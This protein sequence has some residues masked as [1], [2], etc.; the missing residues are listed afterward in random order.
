MRIIIT[1]L[2]LLQIHVGSGQ[3]VKL[4]IP[5][6]IPSLILSLQYSNDGNYIATGHEDN[7]LR[8]WDVRSGKLMHQLPGHQSGIFDIQFSDDDQYL[9]TNSY[10]Q[11]AIL[12]DFNTLTPIQKFSGGIQYEPTATLSHSGKFVIYYKPQ[13]YMVRYSIATNETEATFHGAQNQ[14]SEF[15]LSPDDKY[16]AI[17]AKDGS[18]YVHDAVTG[19]IIDQYRSHNR[20]I[21]A[22]AFHPLK[23]LLASGS[24]EK[25]II[26]NN[27][28]AK[29]ILY[30]FKKLKGSTYD[31]AFSPDGKCLFA[32]G[33]S[34]KHFLINTE[35]GKI[36]KKLTGQSV[37]SMGST[38]FSDNGQYLFVSGYGKNA[39]GIYEIETGK[40]TVFQ[41]RS[42]FPN[43]AD[44]NE[45]ENEIA[46]G[47]YGENEITRYK[48]TSGEI[49]HPIAGKLSAIFAGT[50]TPNG[51][52]VYSGSRHGDIVGWD[53]TLGRSIYYRHAHDT[54]AY[55]F[56]TNQS[57]NR[58]LST[59]QDG[60]TR[61]LDLENDSMLASFPSYASYGNNSKFSFDDQYIISSVNPYAVEVRKTGTG[62]IVHS[63]PK[64]C[65]P[66]FIPSPIKNEAIIYSCRQDAGLYDLESGKELLHFKAGNKLISTAC[67]SDNGKIAAIAFT[68]FW[69]TTTVYFWDLET[70]KC[71]D[72]AY[73]ETYISVIDIDATGKWVFM[74]GEATSGYLYHR[75]SARVVHEIPDLNY[76]T[77]GAVFHPNQ[78]LLVL[79]SG[80]NEM[81]WFDLESKNHIKTQNEH[82]SF[83]YWMQFSA[84][85]QLFLT[86]SWDG[87]F[88]VWDGVSGELLQRYYYF[89]N[90]PK[91]RIVLTQEGYY[92]ASKTA[93][94]EI[95]YVV[96]KNIY[97]LEQFDLKFNRP[98]KVL[99]SMPGSDST[100][101]QAYHAAYQ[102]RLKKMGFTEEMLEDDWH[103]PNL[104][105]KNKKDIP[106][107]MDEGSIPINLEL[108]DEKYPLNRINVWVND[109]ALFGTNGIDI[110][111]RNLN[112]LDTT[113]VIPLA[114]G[115][116]KIQISCL[117]NVGAES[118]KE[119]VELKTTAG[120][121][122]TNLYILA[123]GAG[124]F[125]Q[126]N[127][128][129][130][131]PAK[132][133]QDIVNLFK[134]STV[135]EQVFTKVLINQDVTKE[136]V[137]QQKEFL[138]QAGINDEV[139]VFYAGHGVLDQSLDYYFSTYDMDF[140]NPENNGIAYVEMEGI[141]DG[142]SA[143]KKTFFIDAC[144]SGEIDKDEVEMTL[145]ESESG[146]IKFRTVGA[147]V[148]ARLGSENT[149]ELSQA[150]FT[151]LRRGTGA[152]IISAAGGM[153]FAIESDAYKNGL[154][155]YCFLNGVISK[156]A[157]L[158]SDGE[159]WLSE[160]QEFVGEEVTK[161]SNGQ[162]KPTSRNEN[163][164]L[165]FRLF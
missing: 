141:L 149:F 140:Q 9:L 82:F 44:F 155:T 131:Y 3:A 65:Y 94:S 18:I 15:T 129:L 151:D 59:G 92:M 91:N 36:I 81:H 29:S 138:R 25:G 49:I 145:S 54:L 8:I 101:I 114:K 55:S 98:D 14:I 62:E 90:D 7:Q 37:L 150:L 124:E 68:E 127:F 17:G 76:G 116:N 2:F 102:K 84:D 31:L 93:A 80:D 42:E 72:S 133:A 67:F 53:L 46:V 21:S 89:N 35:T 152:T 144:H 156:K 108:K 130:K 157:D 106:S 104:K 41:K 158:N 161:L 118:F 163:R 78:P 107:L 154:F 135:Y 43:A 165:D 63:F 28:R 147:T 61:I 103:L 74:G 71:L 115:K 160:I 1:L 4:G 97:P 34:S 33:N 38:Q 16:L 164:S 77:G 119:T 13:N 137:L 109:V 87:S 70:K 22:L 66:D 73:F 139:I 26:V 112:V 120:K 50:F 117:N 153:E 125:E 123:I 56:Y 146:D 27:F 110:Q 75:D 20:E 111:S 99:A 48:V 100:L 40:F 134:E 58:G 162:Q 6:G 159:I 39:C 113:L 32:G 57:G 122:E 126:G 79:V 5:F 83:I 10:D 60:N 148:K 47:F 143:L 142:I 52:Q 51:H 23:P 95:Y 69:E 105:I 24:I 86:T 132:D 19:K 136:N 96:G 45:K 64:E 121:E 128:N 12:W 11:S 30:S 85:G 88:I